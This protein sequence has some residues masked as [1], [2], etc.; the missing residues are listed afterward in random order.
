M[1]VRI[2]VHLTSSERR[3]LQRQRRTVKSAKVRDRITAVL[4]LAAGALTSDIME[5]LSISRATLANWRNRWLKRR[6]FGLEDGIHPGRP[7]RADARYIRAMVT[8][9][10]KDPRDL[11]YAFT[12]WTAPRLSEY[13][14]ETTG[15]RLTSQWVTELLRM[16]GFVWRK[17]KRT[18]RNLQN[19]GATQ[20]AQK[21]LR[22]L[23][24]GVSIRRPITNFGL[25]MASGSNFCP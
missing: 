1:P 5:A 23:K 19:P 11:G 10:R 25:P 22:R 15:V 18:I 8:A 3:G 6:S 4:M 14:R 21:A 24:K 20:R 16:H 2:E 7:A 13:L 9:V 12:R 17:T